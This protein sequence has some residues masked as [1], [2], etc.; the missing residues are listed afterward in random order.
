MTETTTR[1]DGGD[2]TDDRR[3]CGKNIPVD[4]VGDVVSQP[5]GYLKQSLQCVGV[6]DGI[7]MAKRA[8]VQVALDTIKL[9]L[10]EQQYEMI[11]A[12]ALPKELREQSTKHVEKLRNRSSRMIS[13]ALRGVSV[14]ALRSTPDL[15]IE[16]IGLQLQ[17]SGPALRTLVNNNLD[18]ASRGPGFRLKKNDWR[19]VRVGVLLPERVKAAAAEAAPEKPSGLLSGVRARFVKEADA[20]AKDSDVLSIV[21]LRVTPR[22]NR[23]R[24]GRRV[25]VP[26][27]PRP[28]RCGARCVLP[29]LVPPLSW[30]PLAGAPVRQV[31]PLV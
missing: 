29:R 23:Y 26:T 20:L 18:K 4:K 25:P 6:K 28:A 10:A 14:S 24:V 13:K 19:E 15:A 8:E 12:A 22:E 11:V 9:E 30:P 2:K 3:R 1:P 5:I 7:N 16:L 17:N 31:R 21:T 27:C